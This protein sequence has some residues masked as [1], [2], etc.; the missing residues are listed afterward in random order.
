MA[1]VLVSQV[2]LKGEGLA[3]D[4]LGPEPGV[5]PSDQ[6]AKWSPLSNAF[7]I[8][9]RRNVGT[10]ILVRQYDQEP[11]EKAYFYK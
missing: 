5:K 6:G 3:R 8:L 2:T 7:N 10:Q 1:K 4:Y 11:I 9:T